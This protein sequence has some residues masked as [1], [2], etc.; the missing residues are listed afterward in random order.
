MLTG[1]FPRFPHI[2]FP[3]I[4]SRN[5]SRILFHKLSYIYS[6]LSLSCFSLFIALY[7]F[8][9]SYFSYSLSS[10]LSCPSPFS[11]SSFILL[12]SSIFFLLTLFHF[13]CF[14]YL[15]FLISYCI[16]FILAFPVHCFSPSLSLFFPSLSSSDFPSC[17]TFLRLELLQQRERSLH[18]SSYPSARC[19]QPLR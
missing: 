3:L 7:F 2:F 14:S 19:K 11:F 9:L 5:F 18:T 10:G 13:L 17:R 15:P 16:S 12:S 8:F 1:L 4:Y 6:S